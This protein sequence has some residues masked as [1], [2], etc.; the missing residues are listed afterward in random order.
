MEVETPNGTEY[1]WRQSTFSEIKGVKTATGYKMSEEGDQDT[2][3]KYTEM[4]QCW[5]SGIKRPQ[6]IASG[7]NQ[8]A[9]CDVEPRCPRKNGL[10]HRNN[11]SR[12]LRP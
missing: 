2:M 8:L 7:S 1:G 3:Q 10:S 11:C 4:T 12:P 6:S 5:K 9:I